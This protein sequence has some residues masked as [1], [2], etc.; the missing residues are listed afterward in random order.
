MANPRGISILADGHSVI[1]E[2][3]D[4]LLITLGI[5]ALGAQVMFASGFREWDD[6]ASEFLQRSEECERGRV[7]RE[8]GAGRL[9]LS[10]PLFAI[11]IL[12]T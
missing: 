4:E 1:C 9:D 7:S 3:P 2:D 12:K 8:E 6:V 11:K 5:P 10:A